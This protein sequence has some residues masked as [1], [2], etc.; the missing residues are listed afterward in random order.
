M[1]TDTTQSP[2][3]SSARRIVMNHGYTNVRNI[4][5]G[6][7]L[8]THCQALMRKYGGKRRF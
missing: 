2:D 7:A 8:L 6:F 5:G 1:E 3:T 4:T